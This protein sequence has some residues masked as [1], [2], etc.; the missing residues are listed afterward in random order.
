MQT[1]LR[2]AVSITAY[3]PAPSSPKLECCSRRER[4]VECVLVSGAP[5]FTLPETDDSV[6]LTARFRIKLLTSRK[7]ELRGVAYQD[8][9][10]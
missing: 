3:Q 9:S 5:L 6:R 2:S 4:T 10:T 8:D 1:V 7:A